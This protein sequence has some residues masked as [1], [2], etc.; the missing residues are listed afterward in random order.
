LKLTVAVAGATGLVGDAVLRRLLEDPA[1]ARVVA[2]TRRALPPH[3]KLENP[4]IDTGWPAFPPL[5]E[6]YGCLGTTR[7]DARSA[8][9]FRA[10]DYDLALAFARAARAAGVRGFGLVSSLGADAS[11][12]F[13]YPRTKGEAENATAGLGF[14]T[15]VIARPSLLLGKRERPRAIEGISET[16]LGLAEPLLIGPLRKYRAVSGETVASALIA[17]VRGRFPGKLVL[18]SDTISAFFE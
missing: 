18:E 1:V 12:R 16:V 5:D 15:A 11:S 2:P 17:S 4:L 13:L 6:A 10:V 9:A 7:K 3:P 8:A 14:D